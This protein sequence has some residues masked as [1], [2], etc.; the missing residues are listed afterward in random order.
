MLKDPINLLSVVNLAASVLNTT[1]SREFVKIDPPGPIIG[2]RTYRQGSSESFSKVQL[3]ISHTETRE[4]KP[5]GTKRVSVRSSAV[6][7]T[8]TPDE[9]V[10]EPFVQIILGQP[11]A[12]VTTAE[13]FELLVLTAMFLLTGDTDGTTPT[14]AADGQDFTARLLNGEG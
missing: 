14:D 4:S 9:P 2:G 13:M 3:A 7:G 10:A 8:G 12:L 11:K 6:K 5:Y 1:P